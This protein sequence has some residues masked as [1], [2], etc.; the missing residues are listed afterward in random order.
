MSHVDTSPGVPLVARG[1]SGTEAAIQ[2]AKGRGQDGGLA[3]HR[4]KREQEGHG[5]GE[6]RV[7]RQ[8][9]GWDDPSALP[10]DQ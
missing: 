6:D 3:W 10:F 8:R 9:T 7:E 1:S 2:G 5:R 4:E